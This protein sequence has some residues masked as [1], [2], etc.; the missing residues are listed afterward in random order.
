MTLHL[1]LLVRLVAQYSAAVTLNQLKLH[2]VT[3][4]DIAGSFGDFCH[5]PYFILGLE[6]CNFSVASLFTVC[7][8]ARVKFV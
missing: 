8:Y 2:P 7:G 4:I 3:V 5:L 1:L 6:S